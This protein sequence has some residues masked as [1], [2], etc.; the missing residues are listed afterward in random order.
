MRVRELE[1]LTKKDL[2]QRADDAF[3]K[4]DEKGPGYLMEA[5]FYMQE[6]DR[7]H[8]SWISLRDLLLEL[9]IIALIGWEIYLGYQGGKQQAAEV[10]ILTN[11]QASSQAT[12]GTLTN[13]LTIT[14]A[15]RTAIQSGVGLNYDVSVEVTFDSQLKRINIANKGRTNLML[16]G[17]KLADQKPLIEKSGRLIV[18]GGSYYILA[19]TFYTEL[20]SKLANGGSMTIPFILYLKNEQ[21]KEYVV[22]TQFNASISNG[23]ISIHAQTTSTTQASWDGH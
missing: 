20:A 19:D 3:Q 16:W 5:Q 9:V 13:L 18:P 2:R 1:R 22:T 17:D 21:G 23:V 15:M 14:D 4:A 12:T 11:L 10:Q 7:R 8:D 6:L